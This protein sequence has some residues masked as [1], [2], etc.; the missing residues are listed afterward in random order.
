[1]KGRRQARRRDARVWQGRGADGLCQ[2]RSEET[3]KTWEFNLNFE[4]WRGDLQADKGGR[5][6][7]KQQE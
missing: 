3:S 4:G 1:M 2:H 6:N 7:Y 5:R